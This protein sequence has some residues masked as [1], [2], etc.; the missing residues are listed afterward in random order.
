MGGCQ[1]IVLSC[2]SCLKANGYGCS[3]FACGWTCLHD[4]CLV[5]VRV[6][7]PG[8]CV[9]LRYSFAE[10]GDMLSV[11]VE[12]WFAC[13]LRADAGQLCFCTIYVVPER[14]FARIVGLKA[15]LSARPVCTLVCV[16]A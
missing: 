15:C 5:I 16:I 14:V 11:C 4:N 10:R 1:T 6:A 3:G 8:C 13:I 12:S 9:G 2:E 7:L